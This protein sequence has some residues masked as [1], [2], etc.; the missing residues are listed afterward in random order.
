MV[1]QK[2]PTA[3]DLIQFIIANEKKEE[4]LPSLII[5][6]LYIYRERFDEKQ[7]SVQRN[8]INKSMLI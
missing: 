6:C 8:R 3:K 7:L 4:Q 5:S 1:R 2:R